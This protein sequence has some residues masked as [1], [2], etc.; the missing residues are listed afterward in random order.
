[1]ERKIV[2]SVF[3]SSQTPPT[4]SLYQ[5]AF[6]IGAF[7][8]EKNCIVLNGGYGGIMEAVSKGVYSNKG[9]VFGITCEIFKYAKPNRFLTKEIKTQNLYERLEK[10]IEDSD[11]YVVFPGSTGTMAE[12]TLTIEM[13]SKF[14]KLK[15]VIFWTD[16]WKNIVDNMKK[17]IILGDLRIKPDN[18]VEEGK[19]KFPI[20]FVSS[21]QEFEKIINEYMR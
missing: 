14:K 3:G 1:M 19:N 6:S 15:P 11:I 18:V 8:A 9:K 12:F 5:D 16:Y 13:L 10:L 7:L 17:L 2:V 4:D 20:Y 21:I